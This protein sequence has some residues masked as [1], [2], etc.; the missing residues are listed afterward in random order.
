MYE[1]IQAVDIVSPPFNNPRE[2]SYHLANGVHTEILRIQKEEEE[3][4]EDEGNI[5]SSILSEYEFVRELSGIII[6]TW[7][8]EESSA[9][10]EK[11]KEEESVPMIARVV[12]GVQ[13]FPLIFYVLWIEK[14]FNKAMSERHFVDLDNEL[15]GY[16]KGLFTATCSFG[17]C[18]F[19]TTGKSADTF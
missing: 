12:S 16:V 1:I 10:A 2:W 13:V 4:E 14:V 17:S 7:T 9:D 3:E 11:E 6:L 8:E 18:C 15:V 5:A 19:L